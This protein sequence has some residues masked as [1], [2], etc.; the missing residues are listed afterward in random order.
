R[1]QQVVGYQSVVMFLQQLLALVTAVISIYLWQQ[2]QLSGPVAVMLPIMVL[3]LSDLL[4]PLATQA[5]TWGDVLY[6]AQ[7][8]NALVTSATTATAEASKPGAL[9][10]L[11]KK[12]ADGLYVSPVYIQQRQ[13]VLIDMQYW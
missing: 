1:L 5:N 4:L 7:E 9:L 6:A 2:E 8:L 13:R 10:P 3:A 11:P 12:L